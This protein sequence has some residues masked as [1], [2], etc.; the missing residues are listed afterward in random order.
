MGRNTILHARSLHDAK[1]FLAYL[2]A[3]PLLFD[4]EQDVRLSRGEYVRESQART[5]PEEFLVIDIDGAGLQVRVSP[6]GSSIVS[7][8]CSIRCNLKGCD[9]PRALPLDER[10]LA[11]AKSTRLCW[12]RV[13]RQWR[14]CARRGA[15]GKRNNA[16]N[17]AR[18]G[19]DSVRR[20]LPTKG[21]GH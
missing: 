4:A 7:L 21:E 1:Y 8:W 20:S 12:C 9:S 17:C 16:S 10:L 2:C 18:C 6:S 13:F 19:T 15:G 3:L 14:G 5:I 11:K